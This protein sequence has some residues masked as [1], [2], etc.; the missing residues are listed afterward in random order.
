ARGRGN[1]DAGGGTKQGPAS[2]VAA[3]STYPLRHAPFH[4]FCCAER[5]AAPRAEADGGER[6]A[7]VVD[8]EPGVTGCRA[9]DELVGAVERV[10]VLLAA[11]IELRR[12]HL[13]APGFVRQGQGG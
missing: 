10:G 13:T 5:R 4:P 12:H 7:A 3:G 1:V 8:D 6:R 11:V 9:V 2:G